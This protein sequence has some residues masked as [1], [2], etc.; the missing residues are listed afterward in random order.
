MS[1]GLMRL[2]LYRR[3]VTINTK[4]ACTDSRVGRHKERYH[5]AH[6]QA[7]SRIHA[8]VRDQAVQG[9]AATLTKQPHPRLTSLRLLSAR[10]MRLTSLLAHHPS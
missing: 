3:V 2:H 7:L 8:P 10:A 1:I 9:A 4:A 6:Q 5:S